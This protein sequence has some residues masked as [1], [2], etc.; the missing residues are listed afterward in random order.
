MKERPILFNGAMVR[1]ILDGSKTQTRRIMKP[2]PETV[3]GRSIKAWDGHPAALLNLLNQNGRKCPYGQPGDRLWVRETWQAWRKTSYE[4]DEWEVC[5]VPPSQIIDEYGES[6][7]E[8]QATSKSMGPWRPSIHM[9]RWASRIDCL[10]KAVRV[11]RLQDISNAD[12]LAEGVSVHPEFHD[13]P[14]TSMYSPAAA[15]QDLWSATYSAGSWE[16]NPWVWI[17]SF[18]RVKP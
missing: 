13:E 5:D 1:A 12:A 18:E 7:I 3:D 17:V 6:S 8:Y 14:R 4:Y 9:P 10:V 15:F 2:Q 16:A 11:E